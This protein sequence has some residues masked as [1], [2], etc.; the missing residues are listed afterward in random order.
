M[1][2]NTDTDKLVEYFISCFIIITNRDIYLNV[3]DIKTVLDSLS[4]ESET[5]S[6]LSG[7]GVF[8]LAALDFPPKKLFGNKDERMVAERRNQLE[9]RPSDHRR[10]VTGPQD[11]GVP[12]RH[13]Q[14]ILFIYSLK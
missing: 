9:V 2:L 1:C 6:V 3:R 12:L 13:T 4:F 11:H 7:A 14:L 8:Q 10:L 5:L